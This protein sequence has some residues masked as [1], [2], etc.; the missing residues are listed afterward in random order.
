[1]GK[2]T[3]AQLEPLLDTADV[4]ISK[5]MGSHSLSHSLP[6]TRLP[7]RGCGGGSFGGAE[8]LPHGACQTFL[9]LP[10]AVGAFG[11]RQVLASFPHS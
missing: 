4:L 1:M 2:G 7:G 3:L 8:R 9:P 11:L 5:P 10:P 6:L